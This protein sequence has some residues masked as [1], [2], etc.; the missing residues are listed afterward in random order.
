MSKTRSFKIVPW[1]EI[2][3][4]IACISLEEAVKKEWLNNIFFKTIYWHDKIGMLQLLEYNTLNLEEKWTCWHFLWSMQINQKEGGKKFCKLTTLQI[5]V[6]R[7][8]SVGFSWWWTRWPVG[9]NVSGTLHPLCLPFIH[10]YFEPSGTVAAPPA[11]HGSP[12]I[13][14]PPS[15]WP[16][17]CPDTRVPFHPSPQMMPPAGTGAELAA[18]RAHGS[19]GQPSVLDTMPAFPFVL[20]A[21]HFCPG[22]PFP[23]E[24]S[25]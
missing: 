11:M 18:S 13:F 14:S 8:H 20:L 16:G 2:Q 22:S 15:I 3:N 24:N 6:L 10:V 1:I 4:S 25:T 9:G 17:Q 19:H 12:L 23:P 21:S 5:S 7:E